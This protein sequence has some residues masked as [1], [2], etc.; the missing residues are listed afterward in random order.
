MVTESYKD[1]LRQRATIEA[2]IRSHDVQTIRRVFA[3]TP[4]PEDTF[5]S[6]PAK[7]MIELEKELAKVH[8]DYD[9]I[10]ECID[11]LRFHIGLLDE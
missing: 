9:K 3:S 7:R 5:G 8:R 2:A 1:L 4:K 6:F 10:D 11:Y